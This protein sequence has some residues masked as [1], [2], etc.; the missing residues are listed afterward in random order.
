M[1]CKISRWM[2]SRAEDAGKPLPR[3]AEKHIA[4][5]RSCGAFARTSD[6]LAARLGDERDAW[7]AK[8][9]EFP[10]GLDRAP[11]PAAERH[12]AGEARLSRRVRPR[13]GL[14]PLPVAAAVLL[15]AAAAVVVF[16]VIP[17][18]APPNPQERAD[19]RAAIERLSSAPERLPAVFGQ[20]ETSLEN[21]RLILERTI[22]S[23]VEYLQAR[24][25]IR[26]ERKGPAKPL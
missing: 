15:L 9:P 13:F 5:C 6:S 17:G 24:L 3:F 12:R 2:V 11:E 8:V 22:S 14:R 21:E 18:E 4:R 10:S 7:L 26:I 16:R 1:L 25:N 23:A 19:A 20:A